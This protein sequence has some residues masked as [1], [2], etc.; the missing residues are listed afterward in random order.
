MP[1]DNLYESKQLEEATGETLRPGGYDLTE[2][3][4]AQCA[5]KKGHEILDLGCGNGATLHYL[6]KE[7]G[8]EGM[9]LDPSPLLLQECRE[10]NPGLECLEGRGEAIPALDNRFDGVLSECSLS[11][12]DPP[13]KAVTEVYRVLKKGGLWGISDLYAKKPKNLNQLEK[14]GFNS[15][16][17]E[18]HNLE[19]LIKIIKKAGFKVLFLEDQSHY[20]KKLMVE[21]V[22]QYGS[23]QRFWAEC[24]QEEAAFCQL[25]KHLKACQPGYFALIA[26]K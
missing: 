20:L 13:K 2:K 10:K 22:F 17:K 25:D 14:K 7:H 5:F 3:I 26:Q 9:G 12:M 18:L 6:Q 24:S 23:M 16:I 4:I 11:L 19:D 15:C 8:I 21:L 1:A